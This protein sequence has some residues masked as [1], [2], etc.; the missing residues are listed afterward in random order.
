METV[1]NCPLSEIRSSRKYTANNSGYLD[2]HIAPDVDS[3]NQTI[4]TVETDSV[5]FGIRKT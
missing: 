3:P 2:V 4:L 1:W 5:S